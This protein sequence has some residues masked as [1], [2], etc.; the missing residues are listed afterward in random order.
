[1]KRLLWTADSKIIKQIT[2]KKII[3]IIKITKAKILTADIKNNGAI[4][5][6]AQ[7]I[8]FSPTTKRVK[9][10]VT[11]ALQYKKILELLYIL[12]ELCIHG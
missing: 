11:L 3:K 9:S 6:A 4:S 2:S 10:L 8:K 7:T 5:A 1:M 12:V